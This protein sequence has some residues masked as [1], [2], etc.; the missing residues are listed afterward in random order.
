MNLVIPHGFETNYTVGFVRGLVAN[1]VELTV[2]SDEGSDARLASLGVARR[3]LRGSLDPARSSAA[4]LINLV[5]YYLRLAG[6]VFQHRHGTIHFTGLLASRLLWFEGIILPCWFR[7][8]SRRYIHTAHNA[9]P[10]GRER[11]K[12]TRF[13]YRWAYRFPHHIVAH[14]RSVATQLATEFNV[15]PSRLAVISIGLNDE[16]PTLDCSQA[17]ARRRL[18]LPV[19]GRFA[20]C[21]GKVEPYKGVDL[22]IEAWGHFRN[23]DT[24]LYIV[25]SCRDADHG[26]R[27]GQAIDRSPRAASI[28]WRQAFVSNDEAA[29][30]LRACDVGVLPYRQISQ[31]GVIFLF[32][33]HGLPIVATSVGS[34]AEF[35]DSDSGI[36]A[37]AA[38]AAEIA[39]ALGGFFARAQHFS[40]EQIARR[41]GQYSWDRQCAKLREFYTH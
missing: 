7:L 24:R 3:N 29:L 26:A 40:R 33:R 17:E 23:P 15:H 25:G 39:L 32:L 22:L 28:E 41:A 35:V 4:K 37:E 30:W 19:A 18:G 11:C 34:F 1:G 12:L 6:T 21:F 14:S 27:L 9:L 10:H 16:I 5:R 36:L 38:T 2:I 31:S 13:I 8:W 20:L